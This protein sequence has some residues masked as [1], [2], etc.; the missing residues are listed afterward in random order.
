MESGQDAL[1]N[2]SDIGLSRSSHEITGDYDR[3]TVEEGS[4]H[5]E[6]D[7]SSGNGDTTSSTT[8]HQVASFFDSEKEV[9]PTDENEQNHEESDEDQGFLPGDDWVDIDPSVQMET[10][11]HLQPITMDNLTL[12]Q[13]RSGKK[14]KDK[15]KHK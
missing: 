9:Q 8:G 11:A 13:G 3:Y 1:N 7:E 6:T 2:D 10:A 5:A 14:N 12:K 4:V 15:K